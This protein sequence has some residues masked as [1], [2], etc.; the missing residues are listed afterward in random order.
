MVWA[1]FLEN[2]E[3]TFPVPISLTEAGDA[4]QNTCLPHSLASCHGTAACGW[5]REGADMLQFL[6]NLPLFRC[7]R[8]PKLEN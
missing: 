5:Q 3:T 1:C 8:F 4:Q 2:F 7:Q 6:Q